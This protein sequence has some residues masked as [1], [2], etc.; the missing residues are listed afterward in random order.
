MPSMTSETCGADRF[1][2]ISCLVQNAN[3]LRFVIQDRNGH[4]MP[5]A[6][7]KPA[8]G[9]LQAI[10]LCF[11]DMLAPCLRRDSDGIEQT[12]DAG[13]ILEIRIVRKVVTDRKSNRSEDTRLNSRH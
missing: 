11:H 10:A 1:G 13:R 2:D 7:E 3:Q 12:R 6:L 4:R 5:I 8:I 9:T